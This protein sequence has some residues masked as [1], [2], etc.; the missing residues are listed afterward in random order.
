MGEGVPPEAINSGFW[1]DL[2][3]AEDSMLMISDPSSAFSVQISKTRPNVLAYS[4]II[5]DNVTRDRLYF[6]P[7]SFIEIFFHQKE[8]L[9]VHPL[10]NDYTHL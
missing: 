1:V 9:R 2:N 10:Y 8:E 3:T 5:N 6:E 7:Y 4:L